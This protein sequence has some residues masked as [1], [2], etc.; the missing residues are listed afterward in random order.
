MGV[1]VAGFAGRV[2]P[3]VAAAVVVS[4]DWGCRSEGVVTVGVPAGVDGVPGLLVGGV[5]PG[6][7][8]PGEVGTEVEVLPGGVVDD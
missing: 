2:E 3:G 6:D 1:A 5:V 8:V 7:V 4:V